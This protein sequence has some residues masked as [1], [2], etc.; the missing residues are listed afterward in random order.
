VYLFNSIAGKTFQQRTCS[1]L[2]MMLF[3]LL[4]KGIVGLAVLWQVSP[5]PDGE[6]E[7]LAEK[8][9]D[10]VRVGMDGEIVPE[11][12]A[13]T[14]SS[15][16]HAIESDLKEP[17]DI[18]VPVEGNGDPNCPNR[19]HIV[20]CAGKYLDLDQDGYLSRQELDVAMNRLPWYG[21]GIS[22]LLESTEKMM[23][24][25]DIDKD[26]FISIDYDMVHNGETCLKTCF[27]RRAFKSS[28]F[29]D[30]DL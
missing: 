14:G 12:I 7:K 13:T 6:F 3:S 24:K 25:C 11:G 1:F 2:M 21:R 18:A 22:Q 28:F 29:P 17:D 15:I 5:V 27:K 9:E 20:K 8:N 4:I 26:G 30:C 10:E 19:S 23:Q 16:V